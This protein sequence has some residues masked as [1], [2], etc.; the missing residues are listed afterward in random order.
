M[1]KLLPG[2]TESGYD[3]RQLPLSLSLTAA[4]TG[5]AVG[6]AGQPTS[7]FQVTQ[8]E[9]IVPP[10][11]ETFSASLSHSGEAGAVRFSA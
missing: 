10:G 4:T 9:V 3:N 11:A 7:I 2:G 8:Y 5:V 1:G 6:N